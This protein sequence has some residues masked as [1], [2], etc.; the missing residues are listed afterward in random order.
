MGNVLFFFLFFGGP[1]LFLGWA[2]TF[3]F[4]RIQAAAIA[5]GGAG[6]LAL[7]SLYL[8]SLPS[9]GESIPALQVVLTGAWIL[10]WVVG[11]GLGVLARRRA[12]RRGA[13]TAP[14]A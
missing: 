1:A 8:A 9:R 11:V 12:E 3:L 5:W 7:L 14:S 6:L 4:R 13:K 10:A 2:L